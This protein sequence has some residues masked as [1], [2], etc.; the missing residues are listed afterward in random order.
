M[1]VVSCGTQDLII[2]FEVPL[3]LHGIFIFACDSHLFA[4]VTLQFYIPRGKNTVYP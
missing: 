2:L 1:V 3:I 4:H